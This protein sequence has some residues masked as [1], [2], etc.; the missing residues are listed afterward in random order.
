ME[1]SFTL[2]TETPKPKAKSSGCCS[3]QNAFI[4][5]TVLAVLATAG[6][7][8]AALIIGEQTAA[9]NRFCLSDAPKILG[10]LELKTNE[11]KIEY[12]LQY[13]NLTAVIIALPIHGPIPPGTPDGPLAVELC[14]SYSGIA[15][16]ITTEANKVKGQLTQIQPGS[17]SP[18]PVIAALR[19]EP[20]RYYLRVITANGEESRLPL[21]RV[22]GTAV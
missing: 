17:T 12:E 6:V 22:C 2:V 11:R 8:V 10:R 1:E 4:V 13:Y 16:D 21:D 5:L 18:R 3:W 7:S 9:I 19:K 15:C 14:G 20:W